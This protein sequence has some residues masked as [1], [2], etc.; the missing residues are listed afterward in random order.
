ML[1]MKRNKFWFCCCIAVLCTGCGSV[2]ELPQTAADTAVRYRIHIVR[3]DMQLSGITLLK[4]LDGQIR[5]SVI[6][7]FGVKAFDLVADRR[8]TRLLQA[9]GPLDK[10]YVRRA[11]GRDLHFWLQ[12]RDRPTVSEGFRTLQGSPQDMTLQ[13]R[14]TGLSYQF[15]LME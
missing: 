13:N 15:N 1:F 5:G 8:H 10:W 6:N 3:G 7:E 11:V 12:H 4:S 9:A 14:R 2:R